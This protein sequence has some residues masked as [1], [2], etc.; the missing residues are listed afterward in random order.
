[1]LRKCKLCDKA[2]TLRNSH[3]Y[4]DFVIKYMKNTGSAY[5]RNVSNPNKREQD[6]VKRVWLC[7][8]DE[9]KFGKTEKWFNE[10]VFLPYMEEK[11]TQFNYNENLFYF[12]VSFLWRILNIKFE[13]ESI[14]KQPFYKILLQVEKEWKDFLQN[15]NFSN[16]L[17]NLNIFFTSRIKNHNLDSN[18][19]DY[20]M[21][22][23][24]D[25]DVFWSND[26]SYIAVYGKFLRF[27]FYSVI[28]GVNSI[29]NYKNEIILGNGTISSNVKLKDPNFHSFIAFRLNQISNLPK[30]TSKQ[31]DIIKKEVEKNDCAFLKTDAAQSIINDELN[32][33]KI[34]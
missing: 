33:K 8:D 34:K 1:M 27:I 11:Q 2:E 17:F 12:G 19:V 13:D 10:N 32:L 23:A 31:K 4:P 24:L 20:Y 7:N 5:L 26:F 29:P 16:N 22:R 30:V 25:G 3:I 15:Q 14:I 6:G 21:T 9:Q 28:R 18:G